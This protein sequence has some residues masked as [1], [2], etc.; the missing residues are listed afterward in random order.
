VIPRAVRFIDGSAFQEVKSSSISIESGN[1]RFVLRDDFLIDIVDHKLIRNLSNLPSVIIPRDIEILGS[2][3]FC[4][5]RSLESVSFEV[6]SRLTRIESQAFS[7]SSLRSILIPSTVE[8]FCSHCFASSKILQ[9]VSFE[10]NSRLTRIE[11]EALPRLYR[12]ITI[13]SAVLF[14]AHDASPDPSELSLCDEDSCPEFGRWPRLRRSGTA[15]D[16]R[17]IVRGGACPRLPLD[18][19]GFE[20]GSVIGEVSHLYRVE[21]D[22][23]EMEIVVEAFDVSEFATL[24]IEREIENLSN[25]RHPLIAA[26]I[27]FAL[28]EGE[29]KLKIGRLHAAGG[30]LA[31]GISSNPAWWTPTA[32]AEAVVGIVLALRFAHGL[33]LLHGGLKADNALFDGEWGIQIADF[34]VMRRDGGFSGEV[35]G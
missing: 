2:K 34:H 7:D 11:S 12:G 23:M 25:L 6:E 27:G 30:S 31:E 22:G 17:R 8:I 1:E 28:S 18:L 16:F 9:S 14:I 19:T 32:K 33:G 29:G 3:C 35:E 4:S 24:E 10:S 15:V 20:E 5:C 26:P 21:K 13:P